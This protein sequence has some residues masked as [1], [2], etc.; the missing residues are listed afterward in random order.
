MKQFGS[1]LPLVLALMLTACGSSDKNN[2][3]NGNW[4]ASLTNP[5]GSPAFA[6]TTSLSQASGT[7]VTVTNLTFTTATPC[8]TAG[9]T[10]TGGFTASGTTSG[11]TTGSFSL[12]IQSGM[13]AGNIFTLNGTLNNNSIA[14][15][16][17]LTGVTSG[18]S[19][20]GNFTMTK[21]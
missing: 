7:A 19:G 11:V 8:F 15:T 6:F 4:S 2:S 21:M 20:S 9:G 18:C 5:N 17:T 14:G 3:I 10:A 13:P 1:L 12:T 16:W